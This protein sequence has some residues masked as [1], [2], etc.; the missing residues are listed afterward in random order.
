MSKDITVEVYH[1]AFGDGFKHVANVI[2]KHLGEAFQNTNSID[3]HWSENTN[4]EV[5]G[6]LSRSTSVGDFFNVDGAW[7]V[8]GNFGFNDVKLDDEFE[9]TLYNDECTERYYETHTLRD[10]IESSEHTPAITS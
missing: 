4:V 1:S 2:C 10:L 5:I 6:E 7:F 8:V 3:H 9:L